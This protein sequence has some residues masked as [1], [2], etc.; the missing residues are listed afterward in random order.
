M[1]KNAKTLPKVYYG[2]HFYPGVA[3]YAE[4]GK[5]P[6]RIYIG[7]E[8]I[9]NMGPTFQGRP[10]Y[11]QHV[12]KVDL[13]NIQQ[14]A[15]GYVMESFFN[16][17]DGKHWAKFIVVSD[18]GHEAVRSGWKLSNAYVP[19]EMSG[20]GLCNGVEYAKE[21]TRGEYEHLAIVPNPR[22][23]ESVILAPDEF[24]AYNAKK[25]LE[26]S[27]LANSIDEPKGDSS[28]LKIFK[29][30]KVENSADFDS[31]MVELPKSKAEVTLA[32]AVTLADTLKNM[33]GY[34]NGDHMVK[35]GE[36]EM[37]VNELSEN[38]SKMKNAE[39]EAADKAVADEAEKKK[40]AEKGSG[41]QGK[42]AAKDGAEG[43]EAKVDNDKKD[44]DG[45]KDDAAKKE[46]MENAKKNAVDH[47]EAIKNAGPATAPASKVSV[48]TSASKTARG[49]ARYGSG[50]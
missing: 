48:E 39:K 7:E 8:A 43:K 24:K 2:L 47:F 18:R 36:E 34:A 15:D 1:I 14:E 50:V 32:E 23:E 27:K 49:K 46:K 4:P 5:E 42:D 40:N 38:Y 26:L 30:T 21:V 10:V 11:V 33:H 45:D 9:K 37:S 17:S 3:E 25:E 44:G 35:V 31:M 16:P 12:N 6:Y 28:M 13:E 22:Y 19:K 41:E 20:G 29:R